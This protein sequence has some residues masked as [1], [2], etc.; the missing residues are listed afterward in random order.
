MSLGAKSSNSSTQQVLNGIPIN[1][2][3]YGTAIPLVYGT[4][5]VPMM[6][7]QYLNFQA[8][9]GKSS[10]S[11]G[12]SSGSGTYT[13]SASCVFGL[14]EGPITE[15]QTV[16]Q[17]KDVTTLAALGL[18]LFTGE[19]GQAPWTYL[20]ENYPAQA[21]PYDHTCY[22]AVANL[23]LGGSASM[24]NYTFQI[25]GLLP[26]TLH[27]GQIQFDAEP[28]AILLDYCTDPNHGANFPYLNTALLQDPG[29]L[30]YKSYCIAMS[31]FVSPYE[32][33]QRSAN[34]FIKEMLQQTNSNCVWSAGLLNIIPYADTSVTGNGR[35]YTPNLEP[36]YEFFDDD[37]L[38]STGG[39]SG[40]NDPVTV[41]RTPTADIYNVVR[42]EYA[43]ASNAY[44]TAIAEASDA[45]D[46]AL[47]G[48]RV[49]ATISLHAITNA[50]L[51]RQIAQLIMQRQLYI[52]NTFVFSVRS[53]YCL[54]EPMDLVSIN[55]TNLGIVDKLVRIT[56]VDDDENDIL[57][58]TAEDVLVGSA[59]APLYNWESAQ[60]YA[61]NFAVAPAMV[62]PPVIFTTPPALAT[63]NG[64][65]E[66]CIATGPATGD[67]WGGCDVYMSADGVTY[68][69]AGQIAGA[70]RYGLLTAPLPAV[71]DPDTTS[72]LAIAF[73]NNF[74]PDQEITSG[75]ASDFANL[76]TLMYVDGEIVAYETATLV[77]TGAYDIVGLRRGQYGSSSAVIHPTGSQW[78]RIDDALFR[79]AFDPGMVGQTLHF[80]FCSWNAV[81]RNTQLQSAV[82]DY[83]HTLEMGNGQIDALTLVGV[84]ATVV[85]TSA[86]KSAQTN[87][88][89]SY[90]YSTDSYSNGCSVSA[91]PG[92]A[93]ANSAV[94]IG[95][96]QNP[97]ATALGTAYVNLQYAF[98]AAASG[99]LQIYEGGAPV[100]TLGTYT[101]STLLNIV[102][103]GKHVAYYVNGALVRSVPVTGL[104]LFMQVC[105][106]NPNNSVYGM[107]FSQSAAAVTAFTLVA[108]ST[109][110]ACA[111][112]KALGNALGA[113]GWGN[114]NFQTKESYTGG[115]FMSASINPNL[116]AQY[117][118]FSTAPAVNAGGGAL[119]SAGWYPHPDVGQSHI[120]F[121]GAQVSNDPV[122]PAAGDVFTITYDNFNFRWY[123]NSTLMFTQFSQ[124]AG[125]LFLFGDSYE[126]NLGFVNIAIGPYSPSTP[127][128]F[129][130]R[131]LCTVSN[132][133]AGKTGGTDVWT[134]GD[135][136]SIMAYTT[137]N[138][139]WKPNDTTGLLM[140]G[141]TAAI[142]P[143]P[144]Y[145]GITYALYAAAG[146]VQIYESGTFVA[147]Y[148]AYSTAD[149]FTI[150][151]DGSTVTYAQNGNT[152]RTVAVSG[153]TLY[154]SLAFYSPGTG[155]NSLDF[156]PGS[157]VPVLDTPQI[158]SQ[159]ATEVINSTTAGTNEVTASNNLGGTYLG[160]DYQAIV[161]FPGNAVG[162]I[163]VPAQ[164]EDCLVTIFV[165]FAAVNYDSAGQV[166]NPSPFVSGFGLGFAQTG[167]NIVPDFAWGLPGWTTA[168]VPF[169]QYSVSKSFSMN[170]GSAATGFLYGYYNN[171]VVGVAFESMSFR[172]EV[173][174]R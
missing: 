66:L 47:N 98:Y 133:L 100:V 27:A 162:I 40:A 152:L 172:A 127:A 61:A 80:K 129:I 163:S 115:A 25:T 3:T 67:S 174:K 44:N 68:I 154:A 134:E 113:V 22:T 28:S 99:S 116:G 14:C 135:V 137:C 51:A 37:F 88:W 11:K 26:Y 148:G 8:V 41:T 32:A 156:G 149:R 74:P 9:Q 62:A 10:G 124:N 141:L 142:Q 126:P 83:T 86:Y 6:L 1:N 103:D 34:D 76:R 147:S 63:T 158:G 13:Y 29:V 31:F 150:T 143:A 85:G 84:G 64:G 58:L 46:I 146:T 65:Y 59:S 157:T 91:Y 169:S 50:L 90:V 92:G 131:G 43:D 42:V 155:C 166:T 101:T 52:R 33:T 138:V 167:N 30:S 70:A 140:G 107:D 72:T 139:I 153:L 24:P 159:A 87:T 165:S 111:G 144:N 114:R 102:Y 78:A 21:V 81:G 73:E 89:D 120:F 39:N 69:P 77:G 125:P 106:Y 118:G 145:T 96:T 95:L 16:W 79:V 60:G 17:D 12:G 108:L 171:D 82:I 7:L 122:A 23:S 71:T 97:L 18:T 130:A 151:Y 55:D 160:V 2:A 117:I 53:D 54:L 75:S 128:Q 110:V 173:I 94:M 5:R 112:T 123:K 132:S 105:F 35:T 45:R 15:I 19:G 93:D 164:V 4:N 48:V 56:E 49:M 161:G 168:S 136:H 57:T 121:A 20:V 104:T 170:A 38:P 119:L 36:I 109:N